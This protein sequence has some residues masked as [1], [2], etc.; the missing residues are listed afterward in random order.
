[1]LAIMQT[2]REFRDRG[3]CD[4]FEILLRFKHSHAASPADK[5]FG[6]L[7][8]TVNDGP[9]I[10]I[11]YSQSVREIYSRATIA[12]MLHDRNLRVLSYH[13]VRFDGPDIPDWP[14]WSMRHDMDQ[15][16]PISLLD[17]TPGYA[18]VYNAGGELLEA[19]PPSSVGSLML[20]GIAVAK[21][22]R[23]LGMPLGD[24]SPAECERRLC[25]V[26]TAQMHFGSP[27]TED[28]PSRTEIRWRTLLADQS[29]PGKQLHSFLLGD[30]VVPPVT[31]EQEAN[32]INAWPD[33]FHTKHVRGRAL[34]CAQ[35]GDS[36]M[37]L[38]GPDNAD[39]GDVVVVLLGGA[40]PFILRQSAA[41]EEYALIGE[42]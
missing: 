11:D 13:P 40:V 26:D 16:E 17:G 3:G 15:Q 5:I 14:S 7:D 4:Y 1:M 22:V 34:F 30:L 33:D 36:K 27:T 37:L 12:I 32:L 18:G 9:A 21:L 29:Q 35:S 10:L 2:R 38:L 24:L 23:K 8:L 20:K 6:F 25:L 28:G 19:Q 31:L 41:I 39:I 42:W